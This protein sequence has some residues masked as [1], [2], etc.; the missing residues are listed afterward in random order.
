MYVYD[1]KKQKGEFSYALSKSKNSA[2]CHKYLDLL[3]FSLNEV[4]SV[5]ANLEQ[6]N[7]YIKYLFLIL[8]KFGFFAFLYYSSNERLE[9]LEDTSVCREVKNVIKDFSEK[10]S[11]YPKSNKE[12]EKIIA[13][14][15]L[16][17]ERL[18]AIKT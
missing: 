2:N 18:K 9:K 12:F 3:K 11:K 13:D 17:E 15:L 1:L 8:K 4:E 16:A 10:M 14:M 5:P 6:D 7:D